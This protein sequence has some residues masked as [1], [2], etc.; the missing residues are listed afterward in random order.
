MIEG[1]F[2]QATAAAASHAA[3]LKREN[4]YVKMAPGQRCIIM[5]VGTDLIRAGFSDR[6]KPSYIDKNLI[7]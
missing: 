7:C 1:K 3:K 6:P 4:K 2:S 5:D